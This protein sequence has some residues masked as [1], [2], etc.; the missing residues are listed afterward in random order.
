MELIFVCGVP[1]SLCAKCD[2]DKSKAFI[3]AF[4]VGREGKVLKVKEK[5]SNDV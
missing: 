2:K 3:F 5:V 1:S 4:F